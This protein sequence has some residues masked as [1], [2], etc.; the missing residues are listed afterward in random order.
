MCLPNRG[1]PGVDSESET[2]GSGLADLHQT[3]ETV[4]A[5]VRK[6]PK[7]RVD[8]MITRLVDSV[9]LLHM[10]CSIMEQARSI[11]SKERWISRYSSFIFKKKFKII[12]LRP[13]FI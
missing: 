6:A 12:F 1:L 3:R 4:V 2:L 11:Y 5:E 8:N 13:T 10:H 7:R 9:H